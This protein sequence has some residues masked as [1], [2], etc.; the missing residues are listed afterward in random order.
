M[1]NIKP[2]VN[3]LESSPLILT[4][5]DLRGILKIS[6]NAVYDLMNRKDFPSIRIT[7][8]RFIVPKPAF[9]EWLYDESIGKMTKNGKQ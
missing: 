5:D 6:R 2:T 8:R 7:E 1:K 3:S 4:A 9:K